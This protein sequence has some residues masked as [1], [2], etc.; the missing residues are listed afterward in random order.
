M[1]HE[2]EVIAGRYE[3]VAHLGDGGTASVWKAHDRTLQR[4]VAIKFLYVVD[5][6]A[7]E[8][9]RKQFLRE[10]RIAYPDDVNSL[11]QDIQNNYLTLQQDKELIASQVL[12]VSEAE[13]A[14][15]LS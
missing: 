5:E 7:V 12:N 9:M 11:V 2:G 15:R 8:D 1:P 13:E 4:E 6:R 14:V 3:L 10:A